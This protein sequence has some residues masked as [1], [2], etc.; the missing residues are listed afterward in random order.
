MAEN[1]KLIITEAALAHLTAAIAAA[2]GCGLRLSIKKT[3]CSG[4]AYLPEIV[5]TAPA[6]H[7]VYAATPEVAIYLDPAWRSMWQELTLDY[8]IDNKSGLKQKRLI[9]INPREVNRCG[10][11]ESFQLE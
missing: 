5:T 1:C 11:G 7:V 4:Y 8:V 6:N 2:Q 10:C 3:G 9:F